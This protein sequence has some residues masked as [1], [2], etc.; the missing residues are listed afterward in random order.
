MRTRYSNP[1]LDTSEYTVEMS[2][3][4]SQELTD[5]I[6]TESLFAQVD[7]EGRYYQLLQE[8]TNHSKDRSAIPILDGMIFLH[9]GNMVLNK[10]TRGWDLLVEWK[11]GSTIWITLKY[12]KA[13][14]PVELAGYEA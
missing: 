6:I 13:S 10:T 9:N 14:N 3:G 7:S 11:D 5:N 12:L 8:I 1:I 4:S 2:Y